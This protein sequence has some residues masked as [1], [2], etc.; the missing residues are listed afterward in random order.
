MNHRPQQLVMSPAGNEADRPRPHTASMV[1]QSYD[2]A[3]KRPSMSRSSRRSEAAIDSLMMKQLRVT[4]LIASEKVRVEQIEARIAKT[5]QD[6]DRRKRML[7]KHQSSQRHGLR[8]VM[9]TRRNT[10]GSNQVAKYERLAHKL[11]VQLNTILAEMGQSKKK[12]DSLRLETLQ[13][14]KATDRLHTKRSRIVEA[15]GNKTKQMQRVQEKK[16]SIR[17]SFERMRQELAEELQNEQDECN[18][19]TQ[20]LMPS[21]APVSNLLATAALMT[22][23]ARSP[24]KHH[25]SQRVMIT[26]RERPETRED[27]ER[28]IQNQVNKAYWVVTKTRMD[29]EKQS[30][31]R[32]QLAEAFE[33]IKRETKVSSVSELLETCIAEE[34]LNFEMFGAISELNQELEELETEKSVYADQLVKL[35]KSMTKDRR[36]VSTADSDI[37]KKIQQIQFH[38]A[39]YDQDYSRDASAI[40][41]TEEG[42]KGIITTLT[43]HDAQQDPVAEV[44]LNN[45]L[46]MNNLTKFLAFVEEKINMLNHVLPPDD[47]A[48]LAA[49]S[50]LTEDGGRILSLNIPNPPSITDAEA[51]EEEGA[52]EQASFSLP[53]NVSLLKETL[54]RSNTQDG[55]DARQKN[56]KLLNTGRRK[57]SIFGAQNIGHTKAPP[58]GLGLM[59][60][61][62]MA[63]RLKLGR[64][65]QEDGTLP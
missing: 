48:S 19:D 4:K 37:N 8:A 47:A 18:V 60:A 6:V 22:T 44:L 57:M 26:D 9:E 1:S 64:K 27:D 16:D 36:P 14:S 3:L 31:R 28:G 45:G 24:S 40:M 25:R 50:M 21:K 49:E 43:S 54:A 34:E 58:S 53:L 39:G 10:K 23:G 56:S 55:K 38:K 33:K 46:S 65:L 20:G 15:I 62:Q 42:L 12:I 17:R 35:E 13:V 59:P 2:S 5:E 51:A 29:L 61:A 52:V 7:Q 30:E 41:S 11:Q 63:G 32:H